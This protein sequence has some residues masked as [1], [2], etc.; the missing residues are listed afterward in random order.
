[1]SECNRCPLP[2]I[3]DFSQN[4][5][6]STVFSKLKLCQAYYQ[7]PVE[8]ED[9]PKTVII[10]P[11]GP[12]EYVQCHLGSKTMHKF[13]IFHWMYYFVTWRVFIYLEDL[14]G[15]FKFPDEHC[16]NLFHVLST[17][18]EGSL[19]LSK[20]KCMWAKP[21]LDFLGHN[22]NGGGDMPIN[23]SSQ[24]HPYPVLISRFLHKPLTRKNMK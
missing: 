7:I 3:R 1:M 6:S 9:I 2:N 18:Q 10:P 24:R 19:R 21:S 17:L 13:F 14:L 5:G 4:F 16:Y 20:N 15:A 11:I 23:K 22:G 8:N 12:F